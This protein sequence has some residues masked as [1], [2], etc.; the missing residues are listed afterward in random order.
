MKANQDF[1]KQFRKEI[2]TQATALQML[3]TSNTDYTRSTMPRQE[4]NLLNGHENLQEENFRLRAEIKQLKS[5]LEEYNGKKNIPI[6]QSKY[7]WEFFTAMQNEEDERK[8]A[9][10][11]Q[12]T[13]LQEQVKSLQGELLKR[14]PLADF[15]AYAEELPAEQNGHA[16]AIKTMLLDLFNGQIA[17]DEKERIRKLGRKS[18][19]GTSFTVQG[20]L[21][22]IHGNEYVKAGMQ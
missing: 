12:A 5:E 18:Q 17:E 9:V 13:V 4:D 22:D 7:E 11:Q 16:L 8:E 20:P 6:P 10:L 2:E 3:N 15:I 21:N 1:F 14:L 19:A